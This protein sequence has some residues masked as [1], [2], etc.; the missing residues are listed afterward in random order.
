MPCTSFICDRGIST[1]RRDSTK[2]RRPHLTAPKI[3]L[4]FEGFATPQ[5]SNIAKAPDPKLSV[6][7]RARYRPP[8]MLGKLHQI[9]SPKDTIRNSLD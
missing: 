3:L 6:E 9:S 5:T 1:V 7:R 2:T 8:Y 4:R